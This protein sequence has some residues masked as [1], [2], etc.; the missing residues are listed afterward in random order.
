ME[1]NLEQYIA[2]I[3]K[4]IQ[5]PAPLES[6]VGFNERSNAIFE[7][8]YHRQICG[9]DADQAKERVK[10]ITLVCGMSWARDIQNFHIQNTWINGLL[11]PYSDIARA[12]DKDIS[13]DQLIDKV[14]DEGPQE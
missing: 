14:Q 1:E 12:Q 10:E 6:F 3:S 9:E 8:V 2:R 11:Q 7:E 5:K 4:Y 13:L